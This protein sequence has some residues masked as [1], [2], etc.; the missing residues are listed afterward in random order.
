MIAV[1]AG[2]Y[3]ESSHKAIQDILK[4]VP[5]GSP[6]KINCA[7]AAIK[8]TERIESTDPR[9]QQAKLYVTYAAPSTA[10]KEYVYN[11]I[12]SDLLGGGMSSPYFTALRKERGYAYS[13]GV[14]YPSR[15]CSSRMTGYIGLQEENIDDAIQVMR[16]LNSTVAAN[17]TE[18]ELEKTKNHMIGQLLLEAETNS[19]T[20]FYAAFFENLGLGFDYMN[21]YVEQI[22]GVK[23]ADLQ[24][25]AK[26]FDKPYTVFVFK[27]Q[28]PNKE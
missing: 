19:R 1:L 15:L 4:A 14:S 21:S 16:E 17:I 22:R 26:I 24:K 5:K 6:V 28:N 12:L 13:V 3:S 2:N 7:S 18:E 27:P 9:I 8:K 20:A 11:K 25:A 23:K 10:D